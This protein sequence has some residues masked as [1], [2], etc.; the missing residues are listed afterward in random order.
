[1]IEL[2]IQTLCQTAFSHDFDSF[3]SAEQHPFTPAMVEVATATMAALP[4]RRGGRSRSTCSR[5]FPPKS[6]VE[7]A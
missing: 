7:P 2:T 5:A 4:T 6:E 1:M 3:S